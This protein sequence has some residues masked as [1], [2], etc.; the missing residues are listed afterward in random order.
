MEYALYLGVDTLV[1]LYETCSSPYAVLEIPSVRCNIAV[2]CS[3]G[4]GCKVC[5]KQ[6]EA[7]VR[8]ISAKLT[9]L[10][11][12]NAAGWALYLPKV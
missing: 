8:L 7:Y 2:S 6:P 1:G 12:M 9:V 4:P 5:L 3:T 11:C 10:Y